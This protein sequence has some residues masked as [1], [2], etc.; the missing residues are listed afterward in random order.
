MFQGR[1][2]YFAVKR[3]VWRFDPCSSVLL[4]PLTVA[5]LKST[6]GRT[7]TVTLLGLLFLLIAYNMQPIHG[8]EGVQGPKDTK[9]QR[10]TK[11]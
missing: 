11:D 7:G 9:G 2:C 4:I 3:G 8:I 1:K 5:Q 6:R 10:F